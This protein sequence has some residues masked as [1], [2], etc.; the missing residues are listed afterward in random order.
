MEN[1]ICV[2]AICKDE[3][4]F[5]DR[6]LDSMKEA[7]YIVVLDTGST[8]GT[9]EDIKIKSKSNTYNTKIIVYQ[10][11]ISP[12]RFDV[13]RNESLDIA[14]KLTD[15]N[16]FMCTDLDEILEPGWANVLKEKWIEGKHERCR[17]KYTWSHTENGSEGRSF[18]Y[19]KIHSRNWKW[20]Y[21]VHE[22]LARE[23][24][25]GYKT[26]ETLNLFNDIHLHHYP[27][28]NKSRSSYLPLLRLRLEENPDDLTTMMYLGHEL[29]YRG[30]YEESITVLERALTKIPG[31]GIDKA[32]C[33]LFMGDCYKELE[34]NTPN[35]LN[36]H[37]KY[38]KILMYMKAIGSDS[39]YIEPYLALGHHYYDNG[40][41]DNC[42]TIVN[43]GIK[44][45][46]RH[47]SWLERDLSWSYDPWDLLSLAYFYKGDKITSLGYA[48]KAYS[49]D[50]NNKRLFD[51]INLIL[52]N[53]HDRELLK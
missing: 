6:W 24:D 48:V 31:N 34:K 37:Y 42:I 7:D 23:N 26:S 38:E 3:K 39:T 50:Q 45:G 22:F 13:A 21:P 1:K 9:Y 27:D 49:Y 41:Y 46:I 19:D 11:V 43:K 17:Y 47:F 30:E 28:K 44:N 35:K 14:Y 36:G 18:F 15:A 52:K 25:P 32:S 8:D 10:N 4:K 33:Y 40:D 29:Y 5:I 16:I 2:Y 12:W 53:S 51:N 20:T